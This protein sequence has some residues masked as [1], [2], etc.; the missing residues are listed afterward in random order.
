MFIKRLRR[1]SQWLS[2]IG[3]EIRKLSAL[4]GDWGS[5]DAN[6]TLC[7]FVFDNVGNEVGFTENLAGLYEPESEVV[8]ADLFY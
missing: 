3:F 4:D 7:G 2:L 5:I 1:L 8:G 6:L